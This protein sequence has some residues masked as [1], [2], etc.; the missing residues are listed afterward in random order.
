MRRA[1]ENADHIAD[2]LFILVE[3]LLH[4]NSKDVTQ[5]VLANLVSAVAEVVSVD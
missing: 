5:A 3:V 2:G 1:V 4:Q